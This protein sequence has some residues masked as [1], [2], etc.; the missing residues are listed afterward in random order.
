MSELSSKN[1]RTLDDIFDRPVSFVGMH[2]IIRYML[3]L[4]LVAIGTGAGFMI[5]SFVSAPSIALLYV[6]PVVI[7]ASFLGWGPSL[8]AVVSGVLAFDFFFTEP[9]YSLTMTN[10]SEIWA[11]VLLFII[12]VIVASVAAESRRRALE[13]T[14]T[15]QQAEALQALARSIIHSQSQQEMLQVAATTLHRLFHAPAVVFVQREGRDDACST[16]GGARVAE[17]DLEAARGSI[18]AMMRTRGENFP[19]DQTYFDFWPV[20]MPTGD[21]CALG[22]DFRHAASGRLASTAQLFE[23]VAAYV[24]SALA[25]SVSAQK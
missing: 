20:S 16:A 8:L 11:T 7:A 12:A 9:Y 23:G 14:E 4:L 13:A 24:T 17:K 1:D 10:P 22:V 6:L 21:N 18:A 3:S 25:R 15:A 19:Y 5:F 2:P